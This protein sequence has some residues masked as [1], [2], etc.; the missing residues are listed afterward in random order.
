[1]HIYTSRLRIR[2][3]SVYKW[4][5]VPQERLLPLAA[6]SEEKGEKRI[7]IVAKTRFNGIKVFSSLDRGGQ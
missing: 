3:I 7:Q 5:R 4:S 1:M 2:C 6:H